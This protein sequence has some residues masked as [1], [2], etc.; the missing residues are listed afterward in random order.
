MPSY[1]RAL[2]PKGTLNIHEEAWNAYPYSKTILTDPEA[3]KYLKEGFLLQFET[4]HVANDRGNRH[5]VH[6]LT[7]D[8][9]KT[10]EAANIIHD[11][12]C[13]L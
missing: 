1:I 9:L 12:N 13:P 8:Q 10:R 2:A 3:S 5:N 7:E 4:Y 6:Q 11:S